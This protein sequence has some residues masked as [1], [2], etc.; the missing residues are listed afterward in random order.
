M[1]TIRQDIPEGLLDSQSHELYKKLDGPTLFQLPGRRR[2]PIFI[3]VLLH[4]NEPVGWNAIRHILFHHQNKELPRALSLFVGNIQAARFQQRHL[5]EQPDFNRIWPKNADSV[6]GLD[7]NVGST[8]AHNM[9]NRV[10]AE[11]AA[12]GLFASIDVHNNTGLNPH[13][14]CVN[15]LDTSFLHL[16]TLFD[17]TVI[18]F[19]RPEGVQSLAFSRLAPSVTLECGQPGNPQ[20]VAHAIEYLTACLN[21]SEIPTHAVARHDIELFHTVAVVRVAPGIEVGFQEDNLDLRLIDNIDHLN[22][23]EL[24]FNTLI[25]WQKNH[26]EL[27]LRTADEQDQEISAHYFHLDGN[28]LRISRPVM[29]SMLT[30][31]TKVIHQD[32][33]C[34]L[35]ERMT[36]PDSTVDSRESTAPGCLE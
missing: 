34:Y 10:Y 3:S 24:P 33:L 23:R 6:Q 31:N 21:L 22:F 2:P 12:T 16:A 8:P 27:A 1:L 32:C 36:L 15:K 18:Y 9:A 17:R 25:G 28:A 11:M 4:G 13:Y 7:D 29:P 5:E 30:R 20:G 14:A 19:T 35:M 26:Q